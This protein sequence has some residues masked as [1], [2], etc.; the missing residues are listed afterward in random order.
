MELEEKI[1]TERIALRAEFA[2]RRRDLQEQMKSL[3]AELAE[4]ISEMEERL[5]GEQ[6]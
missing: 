4:A 6:S 1:K 5:R 3:T 2:E